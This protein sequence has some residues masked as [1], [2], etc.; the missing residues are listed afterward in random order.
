MSKKSRMELRKCKYK[1]KSLQRDIFD[2]KLALSFSLV[3]KKFKKNIEKDSTKMNI[4]P[5]FCWVLI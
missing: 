4:T 3:S 2:P 1:R 5:C